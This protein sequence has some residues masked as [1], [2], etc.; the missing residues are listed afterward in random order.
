VGDFGTLYLNGEEIPMAGPPDVKF[1]REETRSTGLFLGG[2]EVFET[3]MTFRADHRQFVRFQLALHGGRNH[4]SWRVTKRRKARV[5]ANLRRNARRRLDSHLRC[6]REVQFARA[7]Q[8]ACET[9]QP[10]ETDLPS[11]G[12]RVVV[13]AR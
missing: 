6:W 5:E 7:I 11:S 8:Q 2:R 13:E 3:T 4:R 1:L 12:A 10:V 9:R